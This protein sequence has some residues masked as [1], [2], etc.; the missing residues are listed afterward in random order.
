MRLCGVCGHLVC[1]VVLVPYIDVCMLL[2]C[3]GNASV[4]VVSAEHVGSTC[5]SGIV[6]SAADVLWVSMMRGMR[7]VDGV[8]KMCMCLARG[9][10]GG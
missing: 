5:G 4:V 1:E 10:V 3:D 2:E 8:C 7:G 9:A 6:S